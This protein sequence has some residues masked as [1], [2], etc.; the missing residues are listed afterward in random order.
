MT[1]L[2]GDE[3]GLSCRNEVKAELTPPNFPR[4]LAAW[5]RNPLPTW[6]RLPACLQIQKRMRQA[7]CLSHAQAPSSTPASF[8]AATIWNSSPRGRGHRWAGV[9]HKSVLLFRP[10]KTKLV[11]TTVLTPALSSEEREKT[12][13]VLLKIR[14]PG[15]AGQSIKSPRPQLLTPLPGGEDTGEGERK[16]HIEF[17]HF[18]LNECMLP[19]TAIIRQTGE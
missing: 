16:T 7:R 13:A 5:R 14:A 1:F 8:I 17:P 6:D 18:L 4:K 9:E 3:R 12:F 10:Q 11:E 15:F 19:A 2:T